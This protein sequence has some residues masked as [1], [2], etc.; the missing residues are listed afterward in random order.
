MIYCSC[1]LCCFLWSE[2]HHGGEGG[3]D[4]R[5]T[6][7]APADRGRTHPAGRGR[8]AHR[9]RQQ[10]APPHHPERPGDPLPSETMTSTLSAGLRDSVML[11][12][13]SVIC[14]H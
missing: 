13:V 11:Q 3:G 1:L 6:H 14:Q 4:G 10:R 9:L 8:H 5:R 7:T 2:W 12:S